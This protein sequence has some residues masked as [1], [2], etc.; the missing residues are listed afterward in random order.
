[1]RW[2]LSFYKRS[3]FHQKVQE[4]EDSLWSFLLCKAPLVFPNYHHLPISHCSQMQ[5][6]MKQV[7]FATNYLNLFTLKT[8]T[9]FPKNGKRGLQVGCHTAELPPSLPSPAS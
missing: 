9:W 8:E 5:V 4:C 2:Q 7:V 1:M 6:G 3:Y